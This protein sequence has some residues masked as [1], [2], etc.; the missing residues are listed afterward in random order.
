MVGV[1]A[2]DEI[3]LPAQ[4]TPISEFDPAL[5]A[6]AELSQTVPDRSVV[7]PSPEVEP[8]QT[9]P[10]AAMASIV[11]AQT[12]FKSWRKDLDKD[13]LDVVLSR[14]MPPEDLDKYFPTASER[15]NLD[16]RTERLQSEVVSKI[17]SL[18]SGIPTRLPIRSVQSLVIFCRKALIKIL[19]RLC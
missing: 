5:P 13:Y 15:Q 9:L 16:K 8:Q 12:Q 3:T 18:V 6:P 10:P 2:P 17:R 4:N 14:Y 7:S 1:R 11:K 19:R